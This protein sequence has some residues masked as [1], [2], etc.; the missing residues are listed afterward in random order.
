MTQLSSPGMDVDDSPRESLRVLLVERCPLSRH[1][2]SVVLRRSGF[3]VQETGSANQALRMLRSGSFDAVVIDPE[4]PGLT[5]PETIRSL[6]RQLGRA[7]LIV[8]SGR[9]FPVEREQA[10]EAGCN[11]YIVKPICT[12]T[13]ADEIEAAVGS[14]VAAPLLAVHA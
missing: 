6:R 4:V 7:A 5:V 13:F 12:R 14:R 11:A 9:A 3:L 1:M 10:L 2:E 8:V